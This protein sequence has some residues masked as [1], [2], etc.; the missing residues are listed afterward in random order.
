MEFDGLKSEAEEKILIMGATNRPQE[1]DDAA[2]RYL[3]TEG[4]VKLDGFGTKYIMKDEV[5]LS[6]VSS[7]AFLHCFYR[8]DLLSASVFVYIYIL[9][10]L[11]G[12]SLLS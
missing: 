1:L 6:C 2:L 10:S 12:L 5:D 8:N 4:L 3:L 9:Y 7:L 11:I